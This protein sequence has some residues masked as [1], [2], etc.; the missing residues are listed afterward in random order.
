MV[1]WLHANPH[2]KVSNYIYLRHQTASNPHS[3]WRLLLLRL[4]YPLSQLLNNGRVHRIDGGIESGLPVELHALF[5]LLLEIRE[6]AQLIDWVCIEDLPPPRKFSLCSII[7][8]R[9]FSS[10]LQDQREAH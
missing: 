5:Q 9:F 10:P 4:S 2:L 3:L 7:V 6:Q 8:S 1:S